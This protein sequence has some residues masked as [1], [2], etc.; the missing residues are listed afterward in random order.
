MKRKASRKKKSH[1][2][3]TGTCRSIDPLIIV[4]PRDGFF[5]V[6]NVIGDRIKRDKQDIVVVQTVNCFVCVG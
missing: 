2:H 6:A 4:S 3:E 5:K 1:D